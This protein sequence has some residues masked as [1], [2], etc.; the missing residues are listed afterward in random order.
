VLPSSFYAAIY[1]EN[2][3]GYMIQPRLDEL[4]IGRGEPSGSKRI[5]SWETTVV[6]RIVGTIE[7]NPHGIVRGTGLLKEA[8][9]FFHISVV[10]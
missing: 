6:H 2:S 7:T 1:F 4:R 10:D 8:E 9:D 5:I 3:P